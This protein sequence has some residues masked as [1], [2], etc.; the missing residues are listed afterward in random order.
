MT[1]SPSV[2]YITRRD[3]A[4]HKLRYSLRSLSNLRH[5]R[6]WFAGYVPDWCTNVGHIP[7][8]DEL[9]AK[10]ANI[11]R[12]MWEACQHPDVSDE[13]VYMNDDMFIM[14][15]VYRVPVF[16]WNTIRHQCRHALRKEARGDPVPAHKAG[17]LAAMRYLEAEGFADPVSYE[18]HMPMR[19]RKQDMADVLKRTDHVTPAFMRSLYGNLYGIG[20]SYSQDVKP[21]GSKDKP[22]TGRFISVANRSWTGKVGDHVRAT[23]PTPCR[24]ENDGS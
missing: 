24:Y 21:E 22:P 10:F 12:A 4:N 2:V 5:G 8:E 14:Q 1:R 15:H 23:F 7:T 19:V 18:L 3:P 17:G 6:V 9:D 20:G 16:Y 13:F 11:H